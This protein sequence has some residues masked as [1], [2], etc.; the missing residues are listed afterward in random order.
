MSHCISFLIFSWVILITFWMCSIIKHNLY[1]DYIILRICPHFQHSLFI[2]FQLFFILQYKIQRQ[3]E[4]LSGDFV[5]RRA[6]AVW[7]FQ[8]STDLVDL[9]FL[10]DISLHCP[11]IGLRDLIG[12]V[13]G[14]VRGC[15][16]TKP[17]L[18]FKCPST[19]S[20]SEFASLK[21]PEHSC[22]LH[23]MAKNS[24][25]VA[26]FPHLLLSGPFSSKK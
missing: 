10:L 12:C 17:I 1:W 21:F 8:T 7:A 5:K 25:C 13:I 11:K 16:P 6:F 24:Q 26:H 9:S 22:K 23:C 19:S 4:L 2:I 3:H 15:G 18:Y 14:C 20:T